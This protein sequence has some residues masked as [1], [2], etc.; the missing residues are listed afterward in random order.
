MAGT[1]DVVIAMPAFNEENAIEAFLAEIV[2]AFDDVAL[3]LVVVNDCSTDNTTKVLETL[4]DTY[5]L[6][7]HT[8][9]QN[10]G[11][12]PSTL[13]ALRLA[14]ELRPPLVLATDGDGH[15][16]GQTLRHLYDQALASP[17]GAVIEGART[18]RDDPWFRKTVSAATRTLVKS[19]SGIAPLDANTPFRVYPLDVLRDLLNKIPADHMTPNLMVSALVRKDGVAFTEVPITPHKR[20]GTEENGSTW[21]QRFRLVPSRRF[22]QF[23]VKATAQ[24]VSPVKAAQ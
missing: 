20:E 2:D 11:H 16:T 10:L 17:S 12:G 5:P 15:T 13:T 1:P 23:C 18:Q 9:Q 7:V 6:D 8:N 3:R 14:T 21:K 19:H 24:W 4:S 22:L